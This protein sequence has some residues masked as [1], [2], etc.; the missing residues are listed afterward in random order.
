MRCTPDPHF[1]PFQVVWQGEG[2]RGLRSHSALLVQHHPGPAPFHALWDLGGG[3]QPAGTVRLWCHH[4]RHPGR[5]W[6]P[7]GGELWPA[8]WESQGFFFPPLSFPFQSW[9][10]PSESVS[11]QVVSAWEPT[12]Q[13][14][15]WLRPARIF[16]FNE[17]ET[18][19]NRK[20]KWHSQKIN[21]DKQL[22]VTY[23]IP[24]LPEPQ[25]WN[26]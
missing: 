9:G 17:K 25:K 8:S 14:A 2:V 19:K 11:P 15:Q 6:V 20:R 7:G 5:G 12:S 26:N 22:K 23:N 24:E 13:V 21:K 4:A 10:L 16:S 1:L 3:V 18:L